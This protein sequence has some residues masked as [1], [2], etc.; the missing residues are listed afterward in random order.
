MPRLKINN[1]VFYRELNI[2]QEE[3][4][5]S[6][7]WRKGN[8]KQED[9]IK[10]IDQD[11]IDNP[12]P[13]HIPK[14][15]THAQLYPRMKGRKH[16]DDLYLKIRHSL[17]R[18]YANE[19]KLIKSWANVSKE[20]NEFGNHTHPYDLTVVYYLKCDLPEYGTYIT[21]DSIMIPAVNDS[22]LIF[23]PIIEHRLTNMPF[24]LAVHPHNHRYSIVFDFNIDKSTKPDNIAE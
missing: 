15:Q 13:D 5:Y 19:F 20:N 4:S 16:W 7:G 21:E 8:W 11:L 22:L 1:K 2:S 10:D 18:Y 23:N 9:F 17:L 12:G 6:D 3:I 24:E 14:Y